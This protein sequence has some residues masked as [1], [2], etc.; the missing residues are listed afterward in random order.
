[1]GLDTDKKQIR[2]LAGKGKEVP[3]RRG[4]KHQKYCR[5]KSAMSRTNYADTAPS[6]A[7]NEKETNYDEQ[8]RI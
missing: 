8:K 6:H 7:G 1:M 4:I 5:N 2:R 3:I